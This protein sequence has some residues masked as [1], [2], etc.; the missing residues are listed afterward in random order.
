MFSALLKHVKQHAALWI[1]LAATL[2]VYF[3]SLAF[4]SISWD[5]PEMVFRNSDVKHFDVLSFFRKHY[6]G[7]YIPLSMVT[8]AINWLLFKNSAVGHHAINLLFHIL[9]GY[10]VYRLS[11]LLFKQNIIASISAAIFLLH[12]LQTESVNWISE[13]KNLGYATFFLFG[14]IYYYHSTTKKHVKYIFY[15]T[16]SFIVACLF[17]PSAVVFPLALF[18]IDIHIH[19]QF[20]SVFLLNKIPLLLLSLLFGIINLKTQSAD[21]FINYAHQ[22]P[23]HERIVNAGF[24]IFNY[25]KLFVF[26]HPQS[27]IYPF[28]EFD[29]YSILAGALMLL[30]IAYVLVSLYRKK[31]FTFMAI[32][33]FFI[34]NLLLV[35]Q[36]IPFG[37]V[38]YADRYMYLPLLAMAWL[39]AFALRYVRFQYISL[40]LALV[41]GSFTFLRSDTWKTSIAL[42]EDI[43]RKYP[44]NFL[45][46]NSLGVEYMMKGNHDKAIEYFNKA[47]SIAPF[48]YKGF[49]NRALLHLKNNNPKKAIDDLNK[50]LSMYDYNKAYVARASAYYT[51]MDYNKARTDAKTILYKE[52]RNSKA[53]FILGNC[54]NDQN[55][56]KNAIHFYNRA[57][58]IENENADYYFKRSIAFGKMQKFN[59]CIIDLETVL[60]LNPDYIEAYYW[61]GVAKV[62]LKQNP[63]DDFKRAAENN[64]APAYQVYDK[65]CRN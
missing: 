65:F 34:T 20:K 33:L 36:F 46:L 47:T 51:L 32:T 61:R 6:V 14:L 3:K 49:Y 48:N 16:L 52:P 63:C 26:P 7:N 41:L 15:Y 45:A 21:Q 31:E 57:I 59:D 19:Q 10:L 22:F 11:H 44:T 4:P 50:V 40:L 39:T 29:L 64:Y 2:I 25:L 24:A 38:L 27:I 1:I 60:R 18:C 54:D 35:L 30:L 58:E 23:F 12:P 17:K 13:L 56:L 8:H 53:Y 9:N 43:I 42:Y 5:D 37:E 62:N 28:P 55:D